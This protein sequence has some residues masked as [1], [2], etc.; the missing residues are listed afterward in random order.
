[1]AATPVS[2]T[3]KFTPTPPIRFV[4]KPFDELTGREVH[5]F[6]KIRSD[7]F[8]VEQNAIYHDVDG[9]DERA[10]HC[11]GYITHPETQKEIMV[12][13]CRLFKKGD[14]FDK[15]SCVGRVVVATEWRAYGYGHVLLDKGIEVVVE[16]FTMPITISAQL[17]LQQFYT[18]HGFK[19][20][21]EEYLE[22]GIPH[23]EMLLEEGDLKGPNAK[24]IGSCKYDGAPPAGTAAGDVYLW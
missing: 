17:Y 16:N 3:K 21:S 15:N 13:Y 5:D 6:L 18:A 22:D 2:P 12:A 4:V 10:L 24:Y 11:L 9:K 20:V 23:I 1:M 7:V 8:V 19:Q 14:Y